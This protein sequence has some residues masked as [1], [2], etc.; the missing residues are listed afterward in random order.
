MMGDGARRLATLHAALRTIGYLHDPLRSASNFSVSEAVAHA[1]LAEAASEHGA[2]RSG[3]WVVAPKVVAPSLLPAFVTRIVSPADSPNG[4]RV[5]LMLMAA[6]GATSLELQHLAQVAQALSCS[7]T[8]EA[9]ATSMGV[10]DALRSVQARSG[11]RMQQPLQT[12]ADMANG[13]DLVDEAHAVLRQMALHCSVAQC[14]D[15]WRKS[16]LLSHDVWNQH[17]TSAVADVCRDAL[18]V[19]ASRASQRRLRSAAV[20]TTVRLLRG[21]LFGELPDVL[22]ERIAGSAARSRTF[23]AHNR[24]A[25]VSAVSP[26]A[27][28]VRGAL[29]LAAALCLLGGVLRMAPLP[30]RSIASLASYYDGVAAELRCDGRRVLSL[31]RRVARWWQSH[32]AALAR[33]ADAPA[34]DAPASARKAAMATSRGRWSG[35]GR[36]ARLAAA[37]PIDVTTAALAAQYGALHAPLPPGAGMSWSVDVAAPLMNT[38]VVCDAKTYAAIAATCTT[39]TAVASPELAPSASVRVR[40]RRRRAGAAHRVSPSAVRDVGGV[41]RRHR[42]RPGSRRAVPAA[43]P[44]QA[45]RPVPRHARDAHGAHDEHQRNTSLRGDRSRRA[46]PRRVPARARRAG[47]R[48]LRGAHGPVHEPAGRLDALR[49]A[50]AVSANGCG[51]RLWEPVKK[52][53]TLNTHTRTEH[54]RPRHAKT[55]TLACRSTRPTRPTRHRHPVTPRSTQSAAGIGCRWGFEKIR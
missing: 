2:R 23:L 11:P 46:P 50:P 25:V 36:G 7:A 41:V 12:F 47:V 45:R 33:A 21:S 16:L 42:L 15:S 24:L 5:A 6:R 29:R 48:R 14:P 52:K 28:V 51:E 3:G 31:E 17:A 35:G 55:L 18:R 39:A 40:R 38:I 10:R 13:L 8:H 1:A 4:H 43:L 9:L 53:P 27:N 22:L 20:A 34:A 54:P 49:D 44:L 30:E 32:C 26:A 37:R 19:R